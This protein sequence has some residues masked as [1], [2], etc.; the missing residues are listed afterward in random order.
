[1][2]L[3]KPSL[4][5]D[6]IRIIRYDGLHAQKWSVIS[7]TIP[8]LERAPE[9]TFTS[10]EINH[11]YHFFK[12]TLGEWLFVPCLIHHHPVIHHAPYYRRCSY[13]QRKIWAIHALCLHL[14]PDCSTT[15]VTELY[16]RCLTHIC[17]RF[18]EIS[19]FEVDDD[20]WFEELTPIHMEA[21]YRFVEEL[22][23]REGDAVAIMNEPEKP[24]IL[25]DVIDAMI[26]EFKQNSSGFS[27]DEAIRQLTLFFEH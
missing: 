21:L 19:S 8:P 15:H 26:A 9:H 7:S 5:D 23:M 14:D 25:D 17:A 16:I 18:L 1:M 22:V 6:I 10:E 24:F 2:S 12:D 27:T 20:L 3:S 11:F 13:Y 4:P